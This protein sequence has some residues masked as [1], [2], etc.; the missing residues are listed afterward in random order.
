MSIS[1]RSFE[2]EEQFITTRWD[3]TG[4]RVWAVTADGTP[5]VIAT[6]NQ[7]D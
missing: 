5:T 1:I 6:E 4:V 2:P 3:G 7:E